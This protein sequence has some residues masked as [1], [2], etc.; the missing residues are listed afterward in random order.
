M[1]KRARRT[2]D[3]KPLGLGGL[4]NEP[5]QGYA[6]RKKRT[7]RKRSN[8]KRLKKVF[9]LAAKL[10]SKGNISFREALKKAWSKVKRKGYKNVSTLKTKKRALAN[11]RYSKKKAA[12]I[13][14]GKRGPGF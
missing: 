8:K 9:G 4:F 5:G 3:V 6:V 13:G 14:S 2:R 11:I 1:S 12:A 7:W 10:R